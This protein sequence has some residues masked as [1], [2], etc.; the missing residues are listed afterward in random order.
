MTSTFA[1]PNSI[2]RP[3]VPAAQ[4][5]QNSG[6]ARQLTALQMGC[7]WFAENPGGLD[8]YYYELLAA[9]PGAG[10]ECRGLV[11]GSASIGHSS[12]D[13]VRGF[14]DKSD[15]MPR[16]LLQARRQMKLMQAE[17]H[18]DLLVSHFALYTFPVLDLKS[19][20]PL[21]V[22]FHGPWADESRIEGSSPMICWAKRKIERAVYSRARRLIC[23]SNC[24]AR[25]LA[26]RY[27]IP[28]GSNSRYSG[29]SQRRSFLHRRIARA[30]SG[31]FGM[32]CKSS[33]RALRPSIGEADGTGK[34]D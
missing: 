22:H 3:A 24:F 32:G 19:H 26:E 29:R 20:L 34:P 18:F 27:A 30:G 12:G 14:A 9:L 5:A 23:L 21:V 33:H 25:I 11:V 10:V 31:N 16:R 28:A 15:S 8:R 13:L 6:S 4:L 1:I 7:G 17:R 2:V